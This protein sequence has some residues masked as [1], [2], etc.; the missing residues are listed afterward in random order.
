MFLDR[1]GIINKKRENYVKNIDEFVLLEDVPEA[2][3]RL[4]EKNFLIIVVT[5]QSA[6]NRGYL[7]H[8]G[9][10]KIHQHMKDLLQKHDSFI[11]AIYYCPHRPEENCICRKPQPGLLNQAIKDFSIVKENSWL[12]GDTESDIEAAK[13]V[14]IKS[15]KIQTNSSLLASVNH[16]LSST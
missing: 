5:N 4:K 9:L 13:R 12:I 16:I 1:D 15:I 14:G 3:R 11:D 10:D 7:S 6:I 2:I 8:E